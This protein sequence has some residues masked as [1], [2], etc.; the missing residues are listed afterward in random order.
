MFFPSPTFLCTFLQQTISTFPTDVYEAC[1]SML[2]MY[3]YPALDAYHILELLSD[4]PVLLTESPPNIR[5]FLYCLYALGIRRFPGNAMV[6][7]F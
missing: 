1:Q 7:R 3:S 4:V 6:R 2:L 5:G